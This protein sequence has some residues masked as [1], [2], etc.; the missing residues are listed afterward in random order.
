M[1]VQKRSLIFA[2]PQSSSVQFFTEE[3]T[4]NFPRAF[5]LAA[6]NSSDAKF[7]GM[8]E[9]ALAILI[10]PIFPVERKRER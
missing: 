6:R 1:D 9:I 10:E 8:P 4:S 3:R 5:L 7:A 2:L